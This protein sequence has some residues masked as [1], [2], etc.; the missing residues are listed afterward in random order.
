M[1]DDVHMMISIPPKYVALQVIR[2]INRMSAIDL[3]RTTVNETQLRAAR[4]VG[5]GILCPTVVEK[6]R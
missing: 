2:D 3:A 4:F 1:P 5:Q 6:K